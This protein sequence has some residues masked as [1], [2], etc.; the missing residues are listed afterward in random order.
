MHWVP[1]KNHI[2]NLNLAQHIQHICMYNLYCIWNIF[3]SYSILLYFATH[4]LYTI[5]ILPHTSYTHNI[6]FVLY[7]CGR[8][9]T[10]SVKQYTPRIVFM[11]TQR[12]LHFYLCWNIIKHLKYELNIY[13]TTVY[14]GAYLC[15]YSAA[16][17][18]QTIPAGHCW[19]PQVMGSFWKILTK[20]H[21]QPLTCLELIIWWGGRAVPSI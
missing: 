1:D 7:T 17:C 15:F 2:S 18:V 4:I 12:W 14:S 10:T 21:E 20:S 8:W 19:L 11:C 6:Y 16:I 5:S 9:C 13:C 3:V